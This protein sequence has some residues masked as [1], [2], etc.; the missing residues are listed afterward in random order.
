VDSITRTVTIP[1]D[2]VSVPLDEIK[3]P[4]VDPAAVLKEIA[5]YQARHGAKPAPRSS[6]AED[7]AAYLGA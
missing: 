5:A 1:C 3:Q 2:P 7:I 6:V 4:A